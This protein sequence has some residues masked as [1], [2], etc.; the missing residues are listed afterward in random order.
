M[1]I[2]CCKSYIGKQIIGLLPGGAEE[3]L[4]VLGINAEDYG[5]NF[6]VDWTIDGEVFSDYLAANFSGNIYQN[7]TGYESCFIY[8]IGTQ[9][10][11]INVTTEL[12]TIPFTINK[13]TDFEGGSCDLVCYQAS[14]DYG[15]EWRF[16][17]YFASGGV[18]PEQLG[19]AIPIDDATI[20]YNE[21]YTFLGPQISVTSVWNGSQYVVTIN[22]AFRWNYLQLILVLLLDIVF[23]NYQPHIAVPQ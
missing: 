21:L 6:F 19:S 8:Y 16:I 22:N 18:L 2:D 10:T 4:Y 1:N 15:F 13:V 23:V 5:S 11:T 12:A 7:S 14:F 3:C 9:P 17:D 20:L